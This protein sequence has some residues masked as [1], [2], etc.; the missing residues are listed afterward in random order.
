[1]R[2]FGSA[3]EAFKRLQQRKSSEELRFSGACFWILELGSYEK[4]KKYVT[5]EYQILMTDQ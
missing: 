1:V 3:S 2:K 4:S 5:Y